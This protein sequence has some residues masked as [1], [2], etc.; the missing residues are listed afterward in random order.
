M[1]VT[2]HPIDLLRAE[3]EN[4][5]EKLSDLERVIDIL[6]QPDVAM[7]DLRE[8][9]ALFKTGIWAHLRKEEDVL[10]PEIKRYAPRKEGSIGQMLVEH[11]DFRTANDRFQR[12]V[13]RYLE[14]P[15]DGEAFTLIRESGW[16]IVDL[17]RGHFGEE[18]HLLYPM[19][20]AYLGNGQEGRIL[21]LFETVEAH[22]AWCFEN[23]EEFCP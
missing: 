5:L 2:L 11:N 16:D 21:N 3:H 6:D 7:S 20:D 13:R 15:S 8:L 12:G 17:L 1:E 18:D 14:D 22:M 23:L 4:V 9:G 19:A 10:F